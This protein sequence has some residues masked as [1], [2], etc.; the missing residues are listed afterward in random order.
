[1]DKEQSP[2]VAAYSPRTL[3]YV[4]TVLA[5]I[6][7]LNYYDRNLIGILLQPIK[8]SL[9]LSDAGA[10]LLAGP[11]FAIVYCFLGIPI[12]RF[13]DRGNRVAVLSAALT[14]WSIMTSLCGF[15]TS[16]V[17]LMLAR[18][19]VG[20]GEAGGLPTTHA[21]VA[22]Y[23]PE[24]RRASALSVIAIIAS[25]GITA[26]TFIGGV[27][28]DWIGWRGAFMVAGGPGL[29]FALIIILTVREPG[30]RTVANG[31]AARLSIGEAFRALARRRSFL[32]VCGGMAFAALGEYALLVWTPTYLIR[33]FNL[34]PGQLGTHYSLVTGIP[35]IIGMLA[36]GLVVDRWIK[37][38]SRASVWILMLTYTIALPLSLWIYLSNNLTEV[39]AIAFV[40]SLFA[41]IYVGPNYAL[42]QGLAGAKMR[43]TA[44]A[45]YMLIVNLVGLGAGP[46]VAGFLSDMLAP[47]FGANSLRYALCIMLST[48][49]V[50]IA[51]FLKAAQ[52]VRADLLDAA[53]D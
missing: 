34:T 11:A 38:D 52:T 49:V 20:V 8:I 22:E 15:A 23:F 14:I 31:V 24:H 1:M 6:S 32:Y 30:R 44:A 35:S 28:N 25:I 27:L 43:S 47:S 3:T 40:S 51:L 29:L 21:L 10:G 26:G 17:T 48:Y 50:G 33:H 46:Y 37:R 18:F 39:Y 42:I 16:L 5:T 7:F 2:T 53:K 36:G 12:A 19:G 41:G 9:H 45:V 4:L 13:A